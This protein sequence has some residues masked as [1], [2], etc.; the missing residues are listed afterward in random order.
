MWFSL[1]EDK[2]FFVLE[3]GPFKPIDS[4]DTLKIRTDFIENVRKALNDSNNR[5]IKDTY[6]RIIS[7]SKRLKQDENAQ[8]LSDL[9]LQLWK[10]TE[11]KI[12]KISDKI[13]NFQCNR[14]ATS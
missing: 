8:D 7:K 10:E 3:V 12:G 2:L 14:T 4:Q 6:T 1:S 11:D 13:S 5:K 9:M